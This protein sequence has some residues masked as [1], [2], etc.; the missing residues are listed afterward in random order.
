VCAG[1]SADTRN[2][3]SANT[4]MQRSRLLLPVLLACASLTVM[5]GATIAPGLPGLVDHFSSYRGADY[6]SRFIL[7]VPGL[8][9]AL[10]AL[11]A[12][13][14]ADKL[15]RRA[16]LQC[17]I[18]LYIVSGSAGLW[19]D[20]LHALLISRFL[21][22]V[23]VG[24]IMVC[25][26][27]LLTDHYQGAE[28]NRAMGI[29]SSSMAV[30]G[31]V[32][33][34]AG[35]ILADVSWR[36]PFGVYLLPV[37]LIPLVYF[38]VSKPPAAQ[39]DA[40][41]VDGKFPI[42]HACFMY[43]LGL[44]SMLFFYFIP[45][46]LP[47]FALQ[48]GADSLKIAGFAV[49]LSQVF[50]AIASAQYQRL[51]QRLMP[52]QILLLSYM[53]LSV[54][55][56]I[57]SQA[58]SILTL[59]LCMPIIGLG[60]GFNF[61][62]LSI[63]LMSK[64]P[65]SMRGRAAGGMTTAVF[66]GQFVSP[67]VSQPV[68]N[69]VSAGSM[70]ATVD[71][72][73]ASFLVAAVLMVVLVVLPVALALRFAATDATANSMS[74]ML[75]QSISSA[76]AELSEL[77]GSR[78]STGSSVLELHSHDEAFST[79]ALPDAVAF[80]ESTQEV[81]QILKICTRHQCPVIPYGVGTSLEGHVIPIQG[82][83]SVDTS[84]MN[85]VLA[86]NEKDW[87]AIVQPGVTRTQLNDELRA[88]GLMFT[89]DPGADATIGGMTATRASGTNTV[90]Y[91]T[92]RENVLALEVVLPDGQIIETGTRARKSSTGYDLTH[93]FTGSEGTLGVITRI[94]V[95]LHAQPEAV[96]SATCAFDTVSDAVESVI[97]AMQMG[98][99]PGL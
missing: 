63:W 77:L 53:L 95:R 96:A 43:V 58:S 66:I 5:A 72:L 4:L 49:V 31:I 71:G 7:T 60:M 61:P 57:L 11:T 26:M 35:S 81:S 51:R 47:F 38:F 12:G 15:G 55:F 78:L 52:T 73:A 83:V 14:L 18:V 19:L 1:L 16:L 23:A 28:R 24:F 50:S 82:G 45:S 40:G 56:L 98:L 94:T 20:D 59:Y 89:V 10:T 88:T 93:L 42:K 21:L 27:A 86:I 65:S 75:T 6:L 13:W 44:V 70:A 37:M 48:L 29:Q 80:P 3:M 41:V 99:Q 91:G 2:R 74:L 54:G 22:G 79:P 32:F 97:M 30:G 87:D 69:R 76:V 90:R 17:G 67:F 92:M 68:V 25:S 33:I 46:Q 36:A 39:E 8:A 84:R 85:Q 64:V 9:I 62:N 34:S